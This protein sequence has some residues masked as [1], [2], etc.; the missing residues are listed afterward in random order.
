MSKVVRAEVN[1]GLWPDKSDL[2]LKQQRRSTLTKAGALS[3]DFIEDAEST[4][5]RMICNKTGKSRTIG[6]KRSVW[7]IILRMHPGIFISQECTDGPMMSCSKEHMKWEFGKQ[8]HLLRNGRSVIVSNLQNSM[9]S[10]F[11]FCHDTNGQMRWL[12]Q[13][14]NQ[15]CGIDLFVFHFAA[16]GRCSKD[17][18][19][20]CQ[21]EYLSGFRPK[22]RPRGD[23]DRL[24]EMAGNM[25]GRGPTPT[26]LLWCFWMRSKTMCPSRT[27]GINV[28]WTWKGINFPLSIGFRVSFGKD[29]WATCSV[30]GKGIYELLHLTMWFPCA[31]VSAT[32]SDLGNSISN[33]FAAQENTRGSSFTLGR[34]NLWSATTKYAPG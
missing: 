29:T 18:V 5:R 17:R 7:C 27:W 9:N 22:C 28:A 13:L 15:T 24:V 21:A 2:P 12:V 8:P 11:C 3:E 33:L 32:K 10:H 23:V 34:N 6:N 20:I 1:G 19:T 31:D 25:W 4:K 26:F 16:I 14:R 30:Q